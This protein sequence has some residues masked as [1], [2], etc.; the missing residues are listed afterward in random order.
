MKSMEHPAGRD[1]LG[2]VPRAMN[3]GTEKSGVSVFAHGS[4]DVGA[5]HQRNIIPLKQSTALWDHGNPPCS[6]QGDYLSGIG[7]GLD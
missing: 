1:E 5:L 6:R 3:V 4:L 2:A 7:P